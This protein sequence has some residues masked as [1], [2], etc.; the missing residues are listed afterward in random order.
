MARPTQISDLVNLISKD[1]RSIISDEIALLKAEIKPSVRRVGV[2][3]GLFGGAVYFVVSATIILWFTIAAGFAWLYASTTSMSGWAC[4]FF[5]TLTGFFLM[6]I[7]AG[8]FILLGAKS[9]SKIRGP[10]LAPESFEKTVTAI[11]TGIEDG[12]DKVAEELSKPESASE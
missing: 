8:V 3:S 4:V 1:V 9:F 11:M 10:Q 6:L 12:S 2:G 7:V 5:G